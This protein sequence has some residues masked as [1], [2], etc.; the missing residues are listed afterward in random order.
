M[1]LKSGRSWMGYRQPCP[2]PGTRDWCCWHPL[3]GGLVEK[4]EGGGEP[5]LFSWN[6]IS[7][8]QWCFL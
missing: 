4:G 1:G 5:Q 6:S 3:R 2:L 7:V 8:F